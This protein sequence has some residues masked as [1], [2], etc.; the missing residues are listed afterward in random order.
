VVDHCP[1]RFFYDTYRSE[2]RLDPVARLI[3]WANLT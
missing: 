2:R 3:W 1:I